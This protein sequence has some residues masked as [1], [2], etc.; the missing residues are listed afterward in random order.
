MNPE[1]QKPKNP[2]GRP[3]KAERD[4][5]ISIFLN[6]SGFRRIRAQAVALRER[7][8]AAGKRPVGINAFHSAA[9]RSV[10]DLGWPDV[11]VTS[12]RG[13]HLETNITV[14][15]YMSRVYLERMDAFVKR[16]KEEAGKDYNRSIA[17]RDLIDLHL[18]EKW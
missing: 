9:L 8:I 18:P 16:V 7:E 5:G 6:Q 12:S 1:E 2:V 10:I 3:R 17:V 14:N 13:D 15:F 4:R 11:S